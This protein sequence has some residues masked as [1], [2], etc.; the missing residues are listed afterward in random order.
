MN[1]VDNERSVE[2]GLENYDYPFKLWQNEMTHW[3]GAKNV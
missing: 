1:K 3:L 2:L